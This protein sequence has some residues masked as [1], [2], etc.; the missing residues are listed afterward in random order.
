MWVSHLQLNETHLDC[1]CTAKSHC[2]CP[3]SSSY[4][5][6]SVAF[7]S[8]KCIIK[9]HS[10]FLR[11]RGSLINFSLPPWSTVICEKHQK[12]RPPSPHGLEK[13]SVNVALKSGMW[14]N[15]ELWNLSLQSNTFF[16][17]MND[18]FFLRTA[19]VDFAVVSLEMK[20]L[21]AESLRFSLETL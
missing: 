16:K 21:G 17:K 11:S 10:T 3:A 1:E 15:S 6:P 14:Q 13:K 19:W 18:Y 5:G 9:T 8:W 12:N 2:Y 4:S 7:A 20:S